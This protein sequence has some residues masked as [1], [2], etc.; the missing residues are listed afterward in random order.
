MGMNG[1]IYRKER[2]EREALLVFFLA[3]FACSL[4]PPAWA[5]VA[6]YEALRPPPLPDELGVNLCDRET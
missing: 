3:I 6:V 5:G 2:K 4:A 1:I